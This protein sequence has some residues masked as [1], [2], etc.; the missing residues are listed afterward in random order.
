MTEYIRPVGPVDIVVIGFPEAKFD[1][2][3]APA[4]G[5]LI[6][7]G[8]VRLLDLVLVHKDEDGVVTI[9]EVTDVDGDG[10]P[11]LLAI[12][13]DLPGLIS[14]DDAGAAVEGLPNGSAVAMLAW[15]N[16]WAVKVTTALRQ[17]GAVLLARERIPA[18]DV[19]AVLDALESESE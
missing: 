10:I 9:A 11:D 14:E 12:Q 3:I 4:I 19:D 6:A 16:T 1:G 5:E 8:T 17:Q 7:N 15:E 2:T 18:E 13:G